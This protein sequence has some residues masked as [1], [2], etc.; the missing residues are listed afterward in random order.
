VA[1]VYNID[2]FERTAEDF[3]R[4][5]K[6]LEIV[7]DKPRPRPLAKRVWAS[8]AK[9]PEE[10]TQ[11]LFHE[12]LQ[13][14]PEQ[15]KEWIA[16]VDGCPHQIERIQQQAQ[17]QN[18]KLTVICDIIHV[19]EYLWR[20]AWAFHKQGDPAAEDWVN[21][22]FL[23][24]L[25]GKSSTVAG[26][27]RRSATNRKLSKENRKSIDTCATYLL[28]KT[29]FLKYDE[30]LAKGYP[31]ATGI[32]EGACRHLIKDR[33]DRT[34]AKWSIHGAEAVLKLRSLKA[35]GD[36]KKYW[37]FHEDQELKR[38]HNSKYKNQKVPKKS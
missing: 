8:V 17:K 3:R 14:D 24:I 9:P 5:L 31:I 2:R 13:R 35:S 38:N 27:I 12:A 33:M 23:L 28:N 21:E 4:E 25:E 19:I 18:I 22:R 26:G 1:A 7:E 34:G 37:E 36:F 11:E 6:K 20:A 15:E 32:I 29:P 16:L 30:Y 10:V